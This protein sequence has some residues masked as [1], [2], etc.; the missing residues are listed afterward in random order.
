MVRLTLDRYLD[1]HHIT[2]YDLSKRTGIK[3]QIVDHYYK[4]KVIRYDSY[5]LDRFC[6][7]LGCNLFD[8]IE[9]IP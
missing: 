3:F 7:A 6:E 9:Y 1:E 2:R 4:N 8:L 5:I